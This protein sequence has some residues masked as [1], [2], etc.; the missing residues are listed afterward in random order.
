MMNESLEMWGEEWTCDKE[1]ATT[2]NCK[3]NVDNHTHVQYVRMCH[4]DIHAQ[5][6][7]MYIYIFI[8]YI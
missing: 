1:N 6:W 2:D 8:Q 4:E 7:D 3:L 5:K